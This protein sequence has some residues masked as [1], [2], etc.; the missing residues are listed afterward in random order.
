MKCVKC[1]EKA[2]VRSPSTTHWHCAKSI[3]WMDPRPGTALHREIPHVRPPGAGVGG[4]LRCGKDSLSL[5]DIL[6]RSG[7][8]GPMVFI[9]ALGID[10]GPAYSAESQ[11]LTEKLPL[12]GIYSCKWSVWRKNSVREHPPDC[13]RTHRWQTKTRAPCAR[14]GWQEAHHESSG[15]RWRLPCPGHRA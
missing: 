13:G 4:G 14:Y 7:L 6:W 3:S 8:S 5:W 9:L 10:G 15:T 1:S 12:S 2:V 11:R